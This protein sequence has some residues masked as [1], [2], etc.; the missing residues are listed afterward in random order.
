MAD[1]SS[2]EGEVDLSSLEGLTDE[3][4]DRRLRSE[5]HNELP[6]TRGRNILS[7]V[8]AILREPMILLLVVCGGVYLLIGDLQEALVLLA[9]ILV[10]I[11]ISYYQNRKAENALQAL[12]DLSSPRAWVIRGKTRKR[13]EGRE[14]ARGDLLV[15]SEGDRVPADGVLLWTMNMAADESL[16][17]GESVPVRKS[18]GGEDMD[19]GRPGGDDSPFVYSGTLVV[20]GEGIARVRA[21]GPRTE[22]GRIG[23]A[24]LTL[25][26]DETNLKKRIERLVRGLAVAGLLLCTIV[27]VL[28]GL[29]R[30]DWLSGILAGL[31]L[32][33]AMMP[34]EFP[35]ILTIFLALGAWRIARR[36]VLTR[37]MPA[38][39]ALGSATVLCLD[40]TG[41]LTENR[42]SVQT[43]SV[44]GRRYGVALPRKDRLPEDY[45]ALVE[46][47]VL[48][49]KESPFDRM[50]QSI[51][52][53]AKERG[54]RGESFLQGWR[55]AR[56]YP[57]TPRLL[58]MSQVWEHGRGGEYVVG[59]KGAPEAVGRL[60]RLDAE[61]SGSLDKDVASLASEGFRVLAVAHARF[62][63]GPLPGSQT[64][65]DFQLDG[66]VAFSDPIRPDVPRT[67]DALHRAG[68]RTVMIT[69]DYP[70][71]AASIAAQAGFEAGGI[72]T[73]PQL[74]SMDEGELHRHIGTVGIFAR[75]VPDQKLRIV[76]A[77]KTCGEIVAM[78]GDGVN[79]APALKAAHVGVA[80]GRRGT[81]VAREAAALVLLDD[82]ISS[83]VQAVR[84]GRRILD[85]IKKAMAYVL[86]IHVPIAGLSLV[87]VLL[88]W[89]LVLLPVHIVLLELII[90]PACSI[91]F[92]AEPEEPDVMTRPPRD[93]REPLFRRRA[94]LVS[95][96]QGVF[97]LALALFTLFFAASRGYDESRTRTLAFS[98][99]ILANLGLILA[100]RSAS[101]T[102]LGTLRV[103]N[104]ALW[105]LIGG[106]LLVLVLGLAAPPVRSVLRLGAPSLLDVVVIVG[107]GV[108]GFIGLEVLKPLARGWGGIGQRGLR[109]DRPE[110]SPRWTVP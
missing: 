76:S 97:I 70:G 107:M 73:G 62:P 18:K 63:P 24:L 104:P 22:L 98:T 82:D 41:T 55:L 53:L 4:A 95:L 110:G 77:L 57:L 93:P 90:D 21:T 16:L 58:A 54:V 52:E 13:I 20:A 27:A 69:G 26:P 105:P 49:S 74:D 66:L 109:R 29:S 56:E 1:S 6:S 35:V 23:K 3:E 38:I 68:I 8:A 86:A 99:L 72:L 12:K 75:V 94:L 46:H 32:A 7:S 101:R 78:T 30:Q 50:E 2:L 71:T 67:L 43:L 100:N 87:P 11:G 37:R 102:A 15:L 88:E 60:C 14:V 44:G 47:S 91:A 45:N 89:P 25:E 96:L 31:A 103:R 64:A 108:A 92:E 84:L 51:H 42:M 65:F 61:A 17:T 19:L 40:K 80:M 85:N 83:I 79:D 9:S 59:A 39:E 33:M 106:A 5:G 36:N 34:E 48:A 10:V 28:Y 81:D